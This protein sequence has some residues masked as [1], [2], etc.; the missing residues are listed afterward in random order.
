MNILNL[1]LQY[2]KT[3]NSDR[4]NISIDLL[5]IVSTLDLIKEIEIAPTLNKELLKKINFINKKLEIVG[6]QMQQDYSKKI[7]N[8]Y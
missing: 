2:K 5:Y 8:L 1:Y 7:I 4:H 6:Q 3:N